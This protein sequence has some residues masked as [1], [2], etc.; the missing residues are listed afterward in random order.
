MEI[1]FSKTKTDKVICG[2][3]IYC[4]KMKFSSVE[5]SLRSASKM[6]DTISSRRET[7]IKESREVISLS[8]K[9]IISVHT[10]K[11]QDAKESSLAAKRKLRILRKIAG[12]DLVRYILMPEQEF[13]EASVMLAIANRKQPPSILQLGVSASSYILGLLDSIGELRRSVF[14]SI[15]TDKIEDA[16]Q[17]FALMGSLYT[18][19]SSFAVYDNIVSGVKRKLDIARNLVEDTRSVITE[20]KRRGKFMA[21]IKDLSNKI[22][23]STLS[24]STVSES[25]TSLVVSDGGNEEGQKGESRHDG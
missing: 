7:L 11:F 17:K 10:S 1:F 2:N 13:V 12:T 23:L 8:A 22:G 19:L 4:F 15:R 9:T 21:A 3:Q 24:E 20:E 14:D 5:L 18:M 25:K 6:L 16:E